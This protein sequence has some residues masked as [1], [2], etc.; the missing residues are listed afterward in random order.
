MRL[1]TI[2]ATVTPIW[3]CAVCAAG[4]ALNVGSVSGWMVLAALATVPPLV[5]IW[6]WSEPAATMSEI[7]REARR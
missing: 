5:M 4:V 7:I 6:R 3:V 1:N 2:K